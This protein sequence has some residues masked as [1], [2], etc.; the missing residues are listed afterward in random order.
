MLSGSGTRL[1][2]RLTGAPS[3]L[4]I[5]NRFQGSWRTCCTAWRFGATMRS[6]GAHR[7]LNS[8]YS[9]YTSRSVITIQRN[10]WPVPRAVDSL[11]QRLNSS[12]WSIIYLLFNEYFY[13]L[14]TIKIKKFGTVQ[15][16]LLLF[17]IR[18]IWFFCLSTAAAYFKGRLMKRWNIEFTFFL[19]F[20][21]F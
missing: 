16:L 9:R 12:H 8:T 3:P 4:K 18:W 2:A 5:S 10:L 7:S 21:F 1:P 17:P 20:L 14:S 6:T 11:C 15:Q 19:F 13:L